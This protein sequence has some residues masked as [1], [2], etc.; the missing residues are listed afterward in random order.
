MNPRWPPS[1]GANAASRL[2]RGRWSHGDG[3]L[4]P[5][6]LAVGLGLLLLGGCGSAPSHRIWAA[7]TISPNGDILLFA[8]TS[9]SG[10]TIDRLDVITGT[11]TAVVGP[12]H[13]GIEPPV[14]APD[15][16]SVYFSQPVGGVAQLHAMDANGGGIGSSCHRPTGR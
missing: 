1:G 10:T 2:D 16:R 15:G 6:A 4:P 13:D 12:T 11:V 3:C 9:G 8:V 14:F 5:G 7:P